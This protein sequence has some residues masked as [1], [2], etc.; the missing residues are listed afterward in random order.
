MM[1][2][3]SCRRADPQSHQK[4]DRGCQN[5]HVMFFQVGGRVFQKRPASVNRTTIFDPSS[6]SAARA[7]LRRSEMTTA[8]GPK[9]TAPL[10]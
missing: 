1:A 7:A 8:Q 2:A 5:A 10:D 6:R 4:T 3:M 9:T